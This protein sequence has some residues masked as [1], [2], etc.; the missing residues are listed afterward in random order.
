M[1]YK[2]PVPVFF[3]VLPAAAFFKM[4]VIRSINLVHNANAIS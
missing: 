2:T 3:L 4:S 1:A